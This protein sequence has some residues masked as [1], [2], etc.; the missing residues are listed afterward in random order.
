LLDWADRRLHALGG[1]ASCVRR[2]DAD[3]VLFYGFYLLT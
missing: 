1:T 3:L 2:L